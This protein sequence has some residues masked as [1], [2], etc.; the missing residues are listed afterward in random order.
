[1]TQLDETTGEPGG[2][3]DLDALLYLVQALARTQGVERRVGLFWAA[4]ASQQLAQD[5]PLNADKALVQ[6]LL[7]SLPQELPWL[8]CRHV[9]LPPGPEALRALRR[10]LAIASPDAEVAYRRE[11]RYVAAIEPLTLPAG[12]PAAPIERGDIYLIVG[13]LGGVGRELAALLLRH[14][15]ARL[16]LVGRAPHP[17]GTPGDG[18]LEGFARSAA[19]ERLAALGTVRYLQ[20]DICDETALELAVNGARAELGGPL[21]GVV[22][23][24]GMARDESVLE[25]TPADLAGLLAAKVTGTQV[26]DQLLR[27]HGGGLF[28]HVASVNGWFG[29]ARAGAYAAA[30]RFQ[31][32]FSAEQRRDPS[33]HPVCIAFSLWDETGMSRGFQLKAASQAKGYMA[34]PPARAGAAFV[35]ALAAGVS[36]VSSGWTRLVPWHWGRAGACNHVEDSPPTWCRRVRPRRLRSRPWQSAM[37][38]PCLRTAAW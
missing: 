17:S 22:H 11:R 14:W 23:C 10:E 27:R 34:I 21:A 26:L 18:G 7:R 4:C 12:E 29:G 32:A 31:M 8:A 36:P 15:D 28:V 20:A 3:R 38:L 35:A 5:E 9:D 33:L 1:L 25:E 19:L 2:A 30:N 24:A 16:L 13:G 6:G 37:P